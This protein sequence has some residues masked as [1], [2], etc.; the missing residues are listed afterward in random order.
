M[1]PA[2]AGKGKVVGYQSTK[3]SSGTAHQKQ[4]LH[5]RGLF[6]FIGIENDRTPEGN[7]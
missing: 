6:L 1:I 5:F 7:H 2:S 4:I 3:V